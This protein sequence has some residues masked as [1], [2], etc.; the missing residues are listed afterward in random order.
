MLHRSTSQVSTNDGRGWTDSELARL[1]ERNRCTDHGATVSSFVSISMSPAPLVAFALRL[2][3]RLASFLNS[4]A[5]RTPAPGIAAGPTIRIHLLTSSH[6]HLAR[7][8]ARPPPSTVNQSS[9]APTFAPFPRELFDELD[10]SALGTLE[11]SIVGSVHLDDPLPA[12][13]GTHFGTESSDQQESRKSSSA[14]PAQATSQLFIAKVARVAVRDKEQEPLLYCHQGYY[15][16][17]E[18]A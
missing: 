13:I 15:S 1:T 11:C 7:A 10:Q 8:F 5:A 18:K 17:K 12:H 16:L 4:G 2:P 3:S 14:D 9:S 6:E